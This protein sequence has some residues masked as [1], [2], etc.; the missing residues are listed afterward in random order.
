MWQKIRDSIATIDWDQFHFLR[1]A[2]LWLFAPMV[3]IVVLLVTGNRDRK[4]WTRIVQPVLRPF[5]FTKGSRNAM[6]LP[7]ASFILGT[8]LGILALA[9]PTWKKKELP[10]EKIQAVVLIA[11]DVSRS[12]LAT[13]I[14]PS[15]LERAKLKLNDLL[16]A[17]PRAKAGL[18]AYAGSA[19]PVLPFTGD[20][21]LIKHHAVSLENRIMPIQGTE[22][23]ILLR[24]ADSMLRSIL[25]PSTVVLMTDALSMDD[26]T[27]LD[28]FV[29]GRRLR[30]EV[31]LFSTPNG[32]EVP[33]SDHV[34]S[35]QDPF[36]LQNL[37]QDTAITITPLT[38]DRSD[39]KGIAKRISDRLTFEQTGVRDDK[40]WEDEGWILLL[41]V[42]LIALAWFRRGWIIQWCWPVLGL[43]ALSSCGA[44]SK[45]PDW[46]YSKDYQ[47][48]LLENAGRYAPAAE[49]Y[50]DDRRKAVAYFKAGNY[51]AAA[52]LFALDSSA[53]SVYNRGL[54]MA[55]MGRYD[56]AMDQFS[57]A[58][59]LDSSL[60]Q[61]ALK[62]MDKTASARRRADSVL[63]YDGQSA[64]KNEKD[65][66]GGKK[67]AGKDPLK[68]RKAESEDEKLSSDT[69]VKKLPTSGDRVT[70]EAA[71]NIHMGKEAKTPPKDLSRQQPEQTSE[72]ILMRQTEADPSEFLHRRFEL[73][74]KRYYRS[75][76]K[77]KD[78]W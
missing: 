49:R 36:V 24:A 70:D 64:A 1:P 37:S 3:L 11:L 57:R 4:K 69:R 62:S 5:L 7:L 67:K 26:A 60:K 13:D 40:E 43:P 58:I 6:L 8:S 23:G 61:E 55:R 56:E 75:M 32:A 20:Y 29:Q 63:Q 72:V 54:A 73:Q 25:A 38:L 10:G 48:Q 52:D 39:V 17:G 45:H 18:I 53:S 65:L 50:D 16:D 14:Q 51:E 30:L 46:W 34:L 15:R 71:S 9:G 2:A 78:P 68:E 76:P 33:G 31:L 22:L 42:S 41:P 74:I 66:P 27:L 21:Q 12:M 59:D 77:P 47:G 35:K 28:D 19:H 44:G